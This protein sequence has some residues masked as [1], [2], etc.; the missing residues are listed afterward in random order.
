MAGEMLSQNSGVGEAAAGAVGTGSERSRKACRADRHGAGRLARY[1]Q[2]HRG[3]HAGS[4]RLQG[5]RS[6]NRRAGSDLRRQGARASAGGG[7]FQRLSH[8]GIQFHARHGAGLP[9]R[10]FT[11]QNQGHDR[12]RSGG[13]NHTQIHRRRPFGL[14]AMAAVNLCKSWIEVAA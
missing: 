10:R 13:R 8:P 12:R 4:E 1:R 5:S 9:G 6:G 14:N 7:R 2:E 11:R 3:L